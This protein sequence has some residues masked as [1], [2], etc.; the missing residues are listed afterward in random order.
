M[1]SWHGV[2]GTVASMTLVWGRALVAGGEIATAELGE[3]TVDQCTL[4]DDRFTLLAPDDF[5]DG[6]LEVRLYSESGEELARES[7]YDDDDEPS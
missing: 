5:A 2:D 4:Q 7:L 3:H 6:L 1:G